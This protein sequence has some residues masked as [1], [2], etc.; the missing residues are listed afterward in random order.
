MSTTGQG[1]SRFALLAVVLCCIITVALAVGAFWQNG[2]ASS[3]VDD[4]EGYESSA[5]LFRQAEGE[6]Q[7]AGTLLQ[8]YVATG[9][10]T[11]IPQI[12]EHTS[13]GVTSLTAAIQ[14]SGID[15][16]AFIEGGSQ[17]VQGE[18]QIIALRQAG[19][20]QSAIAGLQQLSTQFEEF[21]AV[22]T[23]VI[24]SQDAAA[25][26]ARDDAETADALTSWMVIGAAVFAIGAAASGILHIRR[27]SSRRRT[28]DALPSA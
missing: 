23:A 9:D 19:D 16:T 22:Q 12:N 13:A 8:E 24:T 25:V 26:T 18:G 10:A 20:V 3:K 28:L 14:E 15:G 6:G 7:Q 5:A 21:L 11:L 27:T 4:A 1:S 2:V 17:L